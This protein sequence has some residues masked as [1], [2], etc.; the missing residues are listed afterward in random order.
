VNPW[1]KFVYQKYLNEQGEQTMANEMKSGSTLMEKRT[2]RQEKDPKASGVLL[3]KWLKRNKTEN[4][5][6]EEA[7]QHDDSFIKNLKIYRTRMSLCSCCC[8]SQPYS[9]S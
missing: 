1:A 4:E 8:C 3:S 7:L 6:N 5:M 9:G 2:K